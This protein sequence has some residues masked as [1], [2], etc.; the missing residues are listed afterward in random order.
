MVEEARI[1]PIPVDLVVDRKFCRL[2]HLTRKNSKAVVVQVLT[3][4]AEDDALAFCLSLSGQTVECWEQLSAGE[5]ASG[6]EDNEQVWFDLVS[7]HLIPSA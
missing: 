6:A 3:G 1:T 5:V 2:K 4:N 7:G